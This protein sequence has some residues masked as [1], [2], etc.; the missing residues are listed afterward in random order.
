M[1]C[2]GPRQDLRRDIDAAGKY[3]PQRAEHHLAF[4]RLRNEADRA[5]IE[6]LHH[7]VAVAVARKYDDR[8]LGVMRARLFQ[9]RETV[10]I[11]QSEDEQ[12]ESKVRMLI[13][14]ARGIAPTR[15]LENGRALVELSQDAAHGLPNQSVI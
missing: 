8:Y 1:G 13:E 14:Q 6:C 5:E 9:G 11:R 10:A 7:M 15:R 4:A 12:H 2:L 3:Q